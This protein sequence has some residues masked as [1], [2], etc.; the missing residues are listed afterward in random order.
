MENMPIS[1]SEVVYRLEEFI[2][3]I[4]QTPEERTEIGS[5]YCLPP[6]IAAT[7]LFVRADPR[8][9]LRVIM[10]SGRAMPIHLATLGVKRWRWCSEAT[11]IEFNSQRNY[12]SISSATG[13]VIHVMVHKWTIAQ[14]EAALKKAGV[15]RRGP[16]RKFSISSSE[17]QQKKQLALT[18]STRREQQSDV[19]SQRK[20][21]VPPG[22]P[23]VTIR[24]FNAEI[25]PL[26]KTVEGEA[27]QELF[28][29]KSLQQIGLLWKQQ[30]RFDDLFTLMREEKILLATFRRFETDPS[31]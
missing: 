24:P 21:N 4:T 5:S 9:K 25:A 16:W 3:P 28:S 14:L 17:T 10:I 2:S 26:T 27:L 18:L 7:G 11:L 12:K 30:G 1:K 31:K 8:K 19:V 15:H 6:D 13:W 20:G 22:S 29:G 23:K